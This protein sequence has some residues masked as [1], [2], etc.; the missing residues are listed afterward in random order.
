MSELP[1]VETIAR[2]LRRFLLGKRSWQFLTF[3][4]WE[5]S[6]PVRACLGHEIVDVRR[7]KVLIWN[8]I[9]DI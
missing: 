5:L 1:E 4:W 6:G 9:I 2:G 7:V 8:W 3:P